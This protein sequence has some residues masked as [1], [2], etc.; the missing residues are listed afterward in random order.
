MPVYDRRTTL[1]MK[2]AIMIRISSTAAHTGS[3]RTRSVSRPLAM[4][5]IVCLLLG[6]PGGLL[7]LGMSPGTAHAGV[8]SGNTTALGREPQ[9]TPAEIGDGSID[10]LQFPDPTEGLALVAPP[11]ASNDGGAHLSYP[12][13]IPKGRGITPNL[14]L[15]YDS[16]GGNGWIGQGW[17]LSVGEISVKYPIF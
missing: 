5:L 11:G 15:E 7:M 9:L 8:L 6:Q 3:P 13:L 12:L 1:S 10:G 4:V 16:G 14:S 2:D 17:D